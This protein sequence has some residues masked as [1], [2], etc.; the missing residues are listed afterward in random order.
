MLSPAD[1]KPILLSAVVN[2]S[3]A[4]GSYPITAA[5]GSLSAANYSFTFVDG[6]LLIAPAGSVTL[7]SLARLENNHAR[8]TGVGDAGATYTIQASSDLLLWE[9][10]GTATAGANGAFEFDD[11]NAVHLSRCFYRVALP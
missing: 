6:T 7:S 3:S 11:P 2:I 1:E 9:N 10:I 5:I 4:A 8:I